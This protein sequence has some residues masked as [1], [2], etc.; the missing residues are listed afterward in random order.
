[1]VSNMVCTGFVVFPLYAEMKVVVKLLFG[2]LEGMK[3][4][5]LHAFHGN[6]ES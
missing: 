2:F 5:V 1:M 3:F 6:F 4:N